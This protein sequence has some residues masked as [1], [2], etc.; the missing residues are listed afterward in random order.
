M[1]TLEVS[2]LDSLLKIA[3]PQNVCPM[4]KLYCFICLS[5]LL[6]CQDDDASSFNRD[7]LIDNID[8]T[9]TLFSVEGVS[10]DINGV[11]SGIP[12]NGSILE[13]SGCIVNLTIIFENDEFLIQS[14][15]YNTFGITSPECTA[16]ENFTI[17]ESGEYFVQ[18]DGPNISLSGSTSNYL[19]FIL[20]IN[21][22]Q[23]DGDFDDRKTLRFTLEGVNPDNGSDYEL[24]Y[25]FLNN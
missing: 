11:P 22:N 23:N 10:V 7:F 6:A 12:D 15:P 21:I 8:G 17:T 3:Q 2:W 19:I 16:E 13:T 18:E 5:F 4:K 25:I 14:G 20:N 24:N 1:S 9:Y